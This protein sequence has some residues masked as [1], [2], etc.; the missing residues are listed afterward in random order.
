MCLL[1]VQSLSPLVQRM[2]EGQELDAVKAVWITVQ[3]PHT[4][5]H[6]GTHSDMVARGVV[7]ERD[8]QLN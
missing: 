5:L 4:A 2:L 3:V 1:L 7:V 8:R 6:D